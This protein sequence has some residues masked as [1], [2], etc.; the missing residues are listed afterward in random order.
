VNSDQK[1]VTRDRR[2]SAQVDFVRITESGRHLATN[3]DVKCE[4]IFE[5]Q[6]SRNQNIGA[7]ASNPQEM[8]VLNKNISVFTKRVC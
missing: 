2:E 6:S 7:V 1:Q 3:S 5:V 4:R 8:R